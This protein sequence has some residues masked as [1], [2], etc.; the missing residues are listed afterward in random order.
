VKRTVEV[1][2]NRVIAPAGDKTGAGLIVIADF[3]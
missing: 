1:T 2:L 3:G